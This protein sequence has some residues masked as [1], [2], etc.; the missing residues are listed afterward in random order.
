MR[1]RAATTQ[2]GV[3]TAD[4]FPKFSLTGS[5][6]LQSRQTSSLLDAQSFFWSLGSTV[7]WA[8]LS[9]PAI[10]ANIALQ[11][12]RQEEAFIQY[13]QLV[14]NALEEVDNAL[15]AYEQE[16]KRQGLLREAVAS[17]RRSFDLA[18]QLNDA[19]VVEF[20]NVLQAEQAVS[21]AERQLSI[22]DQQVSTNLLAIYKALGGGWEQSD[23]A[24]LKN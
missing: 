10:Q 3:A 6:G 24:S 4:L 9:W 16:Q 20:I 1:L 19:G 12:S 8:I 15:V 23:L 17:T 2:I 18:V 14:L 22:S 11:G 5:L 13:Q 7:N 21:E